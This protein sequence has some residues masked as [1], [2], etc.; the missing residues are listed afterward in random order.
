VSLPATLLLWDVTDAGGA[1]LGTFASDLSTVPGVSALV[2]ASG[3]QSP[4]AEADPGFGLL[5]VLPDGT[6]LLL[7]QVNVD[8]DVNGDGQVNDED[9]TAVCNGITAQASEFDYNTDGVVDA[10][11]YLFYVQRVLG[12]NIGDSNLDGVFNSGDLIAVFEAGQYEDGVEGNSTWSTGDWNCDGDFESGDLVLALQQ[13]AYVEAAT[14]AARPVAVDQALIAASLGNAARHDGSALVSRRIDR[15]DPAHAWE[16]HSLLGQDFRGETT[17]RTLVPAKQWQLP[18][19]LIEKVFSEPGALTTPREMM[20]ES[21]I[22]GLAESPANAP[23]RW[24]M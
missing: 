8:G 11:D 6:T 5:G 14:A 12:T 22:E 20:L 13:G 10:A 9:F 2:I 19:A 21:L 17:M 24:L 3:F 7:T 4:A 15:R 23:A 16:P 1:Q 18:D